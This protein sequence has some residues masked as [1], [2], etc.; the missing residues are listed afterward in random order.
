MITVF[1]SLSFLLLV[2]FSIFFVILEI[3]AVFKECNAQEWFY[4][5]MFVCKLPCTAIPFSYTSPWATGLRLEVFFH[6]VE[7]SLYA[8]FMRHCAWD[9]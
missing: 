4:L 5:E 7:L 6:F 1:L 3:Q 2:F 9:D 8:E